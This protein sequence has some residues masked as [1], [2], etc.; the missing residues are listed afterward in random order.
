[1]TAPI[2][3]PEPLVDGWNDGLV[4]GEQMLRGYETLWL[5]LQDPT[6]ETL[7]DMIYAAIAAGVT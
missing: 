5:A 6:R 7:A 3:A 2:A 4:G 1:M